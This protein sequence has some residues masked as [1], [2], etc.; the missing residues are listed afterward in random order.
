MH[1]LL[2]PKG[3]RLVIW[4]AEQ[5]VEA[6]ARAELTEEGREHTAAPLQSARLVRRKRVYAK[7][8]KLRVRLHHG[9]RDDRRARAIGSASG[10]H[11]SSSAGSAALQARDAVVDSQR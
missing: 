10:E 4:R 5:D 8:T 3:A 6:A 1:P 11:D 7:G 2:E 9:D